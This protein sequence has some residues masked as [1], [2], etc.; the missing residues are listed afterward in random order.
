MFPETCGG[1]C[2]GC[3][4][5]ANRNGG[6]KRTRAGARSRSGAC[7]GSPGAFEAG[8]DQRKTSE[9]ESESGRR[10]CTSRARS[11]SGTGSSRQERHSGARTSSCSGTTAKTSTGDHSDRN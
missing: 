6:I 11:C 2:H 3:S 8:K 1:T 5:T 7:T 4:N 9:C 10:S